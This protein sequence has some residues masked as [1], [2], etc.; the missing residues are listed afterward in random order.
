MS[1]SSAHGSSIVL[2]ETIRA[3]LL[4]VNSLVS[5]AQRVL[6]LSGASSKASEA[7]HADEFAIGNNDAILKLA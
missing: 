7:S 6:M 5:E 1:R 3:F 4:L 2:P